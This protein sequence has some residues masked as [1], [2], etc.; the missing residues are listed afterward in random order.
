V[1]LGWLWCV[2]WMKEVCLCRCC[3]LRVMLGQPVLAVRCYGE[4]RRFVALCDIRS[5]RSDVDGVAIVGCD[6]DTILCIDNGDESRG[7]R[8]VI[9]CFERCCGGA[10]AWV[11]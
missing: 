5:S 1:H 9:R 2:I 8:G 4:S 3:C 7:S 10:R 6:E 11:L